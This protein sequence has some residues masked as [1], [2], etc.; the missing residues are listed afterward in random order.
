M[1]TDDSYHLSYTLLEKIPDLDF[2]RNFVLDYMH[3]VCLGVTRKLLYSWLNGD[4]GCRLSHHDIEKI[5]NELEHLK[6]YMP[7]E[8]VR[9]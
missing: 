1:H 7:R 3:L 5:S 8:F 2:V 4:R 6:C 9:K